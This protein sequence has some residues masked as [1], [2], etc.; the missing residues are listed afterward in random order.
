MKKIFFSISFAIVVAATVLPALG[1]KNRNVSDESGRTVGRAERKLD[2]LSFRVVL[3]TEWFTERDGDAFNKSI[4]TFT[5]EQPARYQYITENGDKRIET[6]TVESK[7]FRRVNDGDWE[8]VAVSPFKRS[9]D[10]S[11]VARFGEFEGGAFFPLGATRLIGRETIDGLS[12]THYEVSKVLA[13]STPNG[14]TREE[15]IHVWLNGEGFIVRKV[16][17]QTMF[18]DKRFMRSVAN[19]SYDD[20]RIEEPILPVRENK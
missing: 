15:T 20:I 12:V 2:N 14:I 18:A 5:A 10:A 3:T 6:V 16:T 8:S 1:Q 9:G 17:E 7:T 11:T 19:Y 4:E 13:D